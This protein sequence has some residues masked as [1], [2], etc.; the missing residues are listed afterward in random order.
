M[1]FLKANDIKSIS[2][3][4]NGNLL[5]EYNNGTSQTVSANTPQLQQAKSYLQS[6]GK[7]VISQ[8]ELQTEVNASQGQNKTIYWIFGGVVAVL[9]IVVG[10]LVYFL[11]KKQKAKQ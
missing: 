9:L 3:T 11:S 5:V 7:Q 10:I 4:P 6:Q 2:L 8:A 1:N